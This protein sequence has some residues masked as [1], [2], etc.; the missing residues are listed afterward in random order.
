MFIKTNYLF[1]EINKRK[2]ELL[3]KNPN[4]K[5]IDLGIGNTTLPL[6]PHIAEALTSA[7]K[8]LSTKEG[9]SGYGDEQGMSELREKIAETYYKNSCSSSE[10]FVSDGAKCDIARLQIMF[11]YNASITIQNP[12][13]P[14][15]FDSS[16]IAGRSQKIS[17]FECTPENN[18]FPD[19][20]KAKP[21]GIIFIC[22]PN[23]PTGA[24][25]TRAQ[26]K[27]LVDFAKDNNSIIV[28]DSA[29]RD[30]IQDSNLP[31]SIFEIP[32]FPIQR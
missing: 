14:A 24:A 15:Y 19:L 31:K 27:E 1:P 28:F 22:S 25:A 17:Y 13:Y 21:A 8:S 20:E 29:Y 23:N 16:I 11:G 18:F 4:A 10:V 26:L 6:T 2:N 30:F 5:L 9:Y 3:K 12:V 32:L 7:A